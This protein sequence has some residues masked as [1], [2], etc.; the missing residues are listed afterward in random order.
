MIKSDDK[1]VL[2]SYRSTSQSVKLQLILGLCVYFATSEE[3]PEYDPSQFMMTQF[4]VLCCII[5]HVPFVSL[6]LQ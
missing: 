4:C 6:V 3:G 5:G 1:Y 2:N